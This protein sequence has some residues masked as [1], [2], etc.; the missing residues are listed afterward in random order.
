MVRTVQNDTD[1]VKLYYLLDCHM[2]PVSIIK[3]DNLYYFNNEVGGFLVLARKSIYLIQSTAKIL[4]YSPEF[5]ILLGF[6]G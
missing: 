2:A 5:P 6:S 1:C 4:G 3:E